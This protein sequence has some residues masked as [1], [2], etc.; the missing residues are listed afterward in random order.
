MSRQILIAGRKRRKL[1]VL[2]SEIRR[3]VFIGSGNSE[4]QGGRRGLDLV[5]E[6]RR[7]ELEDI[8]AETQRVVFIGRAAFGVQEGSWGSSEIL[9]GIRLVWR[10]GMV[11]SS[12]NGKNGC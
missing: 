2:I 4:S 9:V 1:E 5:V 10:A 7:I 6:G 8:I 3:V 11:N 12:N